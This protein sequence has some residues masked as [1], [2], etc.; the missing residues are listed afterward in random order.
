MPSEGPGGLSARETG[1]SIRQGG[2][3]VGAGCSWAR[4]ELGWWLLGATGCSA[5]SIKASILCGPTLWCLVLTMTCDLAHHT[6][7]AN[8]KYS[9]A[10][11]PA[12]NTLQ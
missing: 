10:M 4:D 2:R 8:A 7:A 5:P 11:A 12:T 3:W 6:P 9:A 1:P